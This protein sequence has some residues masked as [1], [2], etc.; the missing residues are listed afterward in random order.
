MKSNDPTDQTTF[1]PLNLKRRAGRLITD[2][3]APAHDV[4]ILNVVGRGFFWQDLLDTGVYASGSDI[5]KVESVTPST[6]NRLVRM[7]LLA[8]D[9]IEELMAGKQPRRL[10]AHWL[11]RNRIPSLWCEQRALFDQFR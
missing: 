3:G 10:T 2:T 5:A 4:N 7:G 6:V 1:V 11:I 8:P 9:L